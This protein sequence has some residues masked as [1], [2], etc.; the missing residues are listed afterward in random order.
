M[1]KPYKPANPL[2]W[3]AVLAIVVG[4]FGAIGEWGGAPASPNVL[5]ATP[6]KAAAAAFVFGM[7]AA[8]LRNWFNERR[9][10]P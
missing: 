6:L 4:A 10:E 7:L 1:P 5:L 8:M 2:V 9:R 3:G